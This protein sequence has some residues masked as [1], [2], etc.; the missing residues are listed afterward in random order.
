MARYPHVDS[1]RIRLRQLYARVHDLPTAQC[2]RLTDE[3]EPYAHPDWPQLTAA[4]VAA[5]QQHRP[6]IVMMGAH[7]IKQGLSRYLIDL[8]ERRLV[9]HL[10][11]NGAGLI[12][13][14]ELA[15]GDGTSENVPRWIHA[16]QFGL[17]QETGELNE[18]IRD[19]ADRGEGL[20][21]AVGR[22]IEDR[23]P[24]AVR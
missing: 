19:A 18:I 24:G 1:G 4:L 3:F 7:P 20:G 6:V 9:T 15:R 10:A 14:F 21:E 12:H 11:T 2:K 17:W 16:G 8:V 13:D 22:V 5:R 23:Y